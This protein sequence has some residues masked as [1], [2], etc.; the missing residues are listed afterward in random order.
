LWSEP[1]G[2]SSN[3]VLLPVGLP[4][5]AALIVGSKGY[6]HFHANGAGSAR[7]VPAGG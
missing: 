4:E 6:F 7:V 3:V 1:S 5:S 2:V